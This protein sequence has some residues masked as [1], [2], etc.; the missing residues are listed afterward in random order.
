MVPE[1]DRILV[2]HTRVNECQRV[3]SSRHKHT[4]R[5]WYFKAFSY[6]WSIIIYINI[7]SGAFGPG[8]TV[9]GMSGSVNTSGTAPPY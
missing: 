8:S 4:G 9:G 2:L 3:L 1:R 7:R 6:F 5:T